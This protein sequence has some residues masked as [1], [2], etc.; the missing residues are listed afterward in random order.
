M[1]IKGDSSKA[2]LLT[3]LGRVPLPPGRTALRYEANQQNT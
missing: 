1:I 3:V 2:K